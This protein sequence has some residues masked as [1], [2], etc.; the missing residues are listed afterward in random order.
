M[1]LSL[2]G[3]LKLLPSKEDA[4]Q[5]GLAL[6][7]GHLQRFEAVEHESLAGWITRDRQTGRVYDAVGPIDQSAR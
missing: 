6:G 2:N 3:P 7:S 5:L 4:E 1:S